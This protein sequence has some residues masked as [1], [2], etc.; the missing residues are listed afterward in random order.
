MKENITMKNRINRAVIVAATLLTATT[1]C[2]LYTKFEKPQTDIETS[3][4]GEEVTM[5]DNSLSHDLVSWRDLFNDEYLRGYIEQAL[6]A[7]SDLRI[8]ALNISQ[9]ER[10]LA[11]AKM[12][13]LPT[14]S[15]S[16]EGTTTSFDGSPAVNTYKVPL[17]ASW[18][19]DLFGKLR[20]AKEMSKAAVEQSQEYAQMV[21][22]QLI[23]GVASNYYSLVLANNQHQIATQSIEI[24]RQNVEAIKSLK[25]VGMQ[26]QAAVD[27]S[28]AT[29]KEMELTLKTI[30][31]SINQIENNLA[32]LLNKTPQKF[33]HN[34]SFVIDQ[35]SDLSQSISLATLSLRPDVRLAEIAL[36]SN[37]YGVNYARAQL[38][39][40]LRL[41]GVGGW[42]NN[43]GGAIV[44]PGA[45]LLSAVGSVTQPLFMAGVNRANLNNAK[46]QYEQQL[47]AFEKALL[48][49][50]KEVN[51]AMVAIS[52]TTE[53]LALSN[54]RVALLSSATTITRDLME[55]GRA[56][57]IEV[58]MAQNS[59]LSAQLNHANL[60]YDACINRITLFKAL[61][62]GREEIE[63]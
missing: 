24:M 38:Y 4:V 51:D 33:A 17:T 13:Y 41:T 47:I 40:S 9:A 3:L 26:N 50:G 36:R 1:S 46:D 18:E 10:H 27:Q 8:A 29:L 49:A 30:E 25:E 43:G 23:A 6:A 55:A 61:G 14:L 42:T 57:Y 58:L 32:L 20:N 2:G 63:E 56:N 12:A 48:V 53:K 44:D 37:F 45:L 21:R 19:I 62:G 34:S 22:T 59:Y 60:D 15:L 35:E 52:T 28:A 11:T 5:V 39:P 54:D 31:Q 16:G 7:N